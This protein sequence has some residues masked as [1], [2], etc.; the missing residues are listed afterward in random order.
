MNLLPLLAAALALVALSGKRRSGNPL[1]QRACPPLG[2]RIL[3]I[4]DSNGVGLAG[5]S[6]QGVALPRPLLRLAENCG[7]I[8]A[9]D[10]LGGKGAPYFA[11]R[12]EALLDQSKPTLLL[13]NL[14][15]NDYG[16][17]D[18]EHVAASIQKIVNAAN[19]RG[20]QVIWISPPATPLTDK[21]GVLGMWRA[22]GVTELQTPTLPDR[23]DGIHYTADGYEELAA[24][25]WAFVS[26]EAR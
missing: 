3:F 24:L 18:P 13:I 26:S 10:V 14:G 17:T 11:S 22:T 6:F 2:T 21:I 25:I 7:I 12:I 8:M 1:E 15:P 16:R 5:A 9:V 20:V 19:D 23:T 4:G